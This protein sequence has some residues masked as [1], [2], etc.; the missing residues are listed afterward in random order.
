MRKVG[1]R[2][3]KRRKSEG[4]GGRRCDGERGFTEKVKH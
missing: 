1:K 4:G 2:R 3:K